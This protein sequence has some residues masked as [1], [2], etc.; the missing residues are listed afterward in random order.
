M[1]ESTVKETVSTVTRKGQVTIPVEIR[2]AWGLEPGDKVVFARTGEQVTIK[3]ASSGL[4]AG[5]G[6]VGPKARP[7]DFARVRKAAE[8][9]IAEEVAGE[10]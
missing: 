3:P 8:K 9:A 4:L 1:M 7:E 2:A 5:Y 6:A 10:G